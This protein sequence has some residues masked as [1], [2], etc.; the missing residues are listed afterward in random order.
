MPGSV[1]H[2]EVHYQVASKQEVEVMYEG[3]Q[4]GEGRAGRKVMVVVAGL[5]VLL[6]LAGAGVALW[7]TGVLGG[8]SQSESL[9]SSAPHQS[10]SP[11]TT[12]ST[13]SPSVPPTLAS[14][15]TTTERLLSTPSISPSSGESRSQT[16]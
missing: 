11:S 13:T 5:V 1:S 8:D 12:P 7:Q 9:Q 4:A 10:S 15:P 14:S 6:L 3:R 16:K 2:P